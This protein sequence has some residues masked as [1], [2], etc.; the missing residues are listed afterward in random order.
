MFEFSFDWW[1]C[2]DQ[3]ILKIIEVWVLREHL[4]SSV[5]VAKSGPCVHVNPT[6][7]KENAIHLQGRTLTWWN[8]VHSVLL[9]PQ[10]FTYIWDYL[11]C[12]SATIIAVLNLCLT[13]N[14]NLQNTMT[15]SF[16][17]TIH[18]L[19]TIFLQQLP[20]EHTQISI[21]QLVT[22]CIRNCLQK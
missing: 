10:P 6:G 9:T 18:G 20:E 4:A 15:S 3:N 11:R 21:V 1:R 17:A 19:M 12:S 22:I 16:W 5:L 8:M 7:P 13:G 14:Y 2:T